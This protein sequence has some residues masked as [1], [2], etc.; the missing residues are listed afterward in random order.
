MK[1]KVQFVSIVPDE[2]VVGSNPEMADMGNPSGLI[3]G[4]VYQ[5]EAVT[6]HGRRFFHDFR[7]ENEVTPALAKLAARV[8]AKGEIDTDFWTEGY[9][10]YGSSAWEAADR[11]R[12]AAWAFNPA[13]AG[14]V[15]DY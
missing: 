11:D 15:R 3:Y 1:I 4:K 10:V 6:A 9:E 5:V 12:A 14:T 2:I 7:S 13:T 8:E